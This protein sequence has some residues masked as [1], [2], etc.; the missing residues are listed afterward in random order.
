MKVK[1]LLSALLFALALPTVYAQDHPPHMGVAIQNTEDNADKSVTIVHL[2][3]V[4]GKEVTAFNISA[5]QKLPDGKIS[6]PSANSYD[7]LGGY[8]SSGKAFS[9]DS[10]YDAQVGHSDG[11][12][13]IVDV[14]IY[15]DGTA[16]VLN[17]DG[18]KRLIDR[19]KVR[20]QVLEKVNEAIEKVLADPAA[21]HPT[22]GVVAQL[23]AV[24]DDEEKKADIDSNG[25]IQGNASPSES[26]LENQ[27]RDLT[28]YVNRNEEAPL[29]E[30][31]QRNKSEIEKLTPHVQVTET[32]Q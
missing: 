7:L 14:V 27:I 19:R 3:N 18:F 13:L 22:A 12:T 1:L 31:L 30:M 15:A 29:D 11:T 9:P 6:P 20:F 2:V 5:N 21:E 32:Q 10:T 16:Q 28:R 23:K 17:Q 24:L 25:R 26:E 8:L 4:S